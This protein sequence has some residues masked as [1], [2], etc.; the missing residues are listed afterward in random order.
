M[1]RAS[2]FFISAKLKKGPLTLQGAEFHFMVR[3]SQHQT[4]ET[5]TLFDGTARDG[6][7]KR[8][9]KRKSSMFRET[10]PA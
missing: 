6:K 8:K 10:P 1:N 3:V 7:R 9:R 5:V 4:G 2:I